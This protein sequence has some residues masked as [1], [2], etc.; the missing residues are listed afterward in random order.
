MPTRPTAGYPDAERLDLVEEIHGHQIADPYRWLEDF[1]DPRTRDW[2]AQQDE[3]FARW[4][5]HWLGDEAS[6]QLRRRLAALADAGSVTVPVW[7]GERQFFT[8]RAPGQE[9]EVLLT[10]GPDGADRALIDPAALDPSGSTTLDAWFPSQEGQLLAYLMS[11]GGTEQS[12]L[13]VM[14][15][16]TGEIVDGPIEET[17]HSP[18]AW[19][20]GGTAFYYGRRPA[21]DQAAR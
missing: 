12:L 18:V 15:V 8:R 11:S 6:G 17:S 14:K 13:R 19:L 7:R 16:A 9:H 20:P 4:Q 21:P 2:C 1:D 5:G 3:L 10:V